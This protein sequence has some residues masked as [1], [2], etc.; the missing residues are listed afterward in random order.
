MSAT[1][2]TDTKEEM[3]VFKPRPSTG[4]MWVLLL[5]L[6]LLIGGGSYLATGSASA[7]GLLGYLLPVVLGGLG[8][9]CLLLVLFFPAMRYQVGNGRLI[10][11]YGPVLRYVIF[12]DAIERIERRNLQ[13][14]IVSSFRFPGLALFGVQ[15]PEVG[16]VKMCATA[17]GDRILL[18]ETPQGKYGV[19]PAD[20]EAFVAEL[21]SGMEK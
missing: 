12:L 16:N 4:W 5:G 17:A 21:R 20:E 3:K 9:F 2:L 6:V 14:G 7:L 11:T 15:Y 10:V 8:I 13:I 18:I 19:T 1:E